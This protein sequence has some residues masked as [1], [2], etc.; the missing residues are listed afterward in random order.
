MLDMNRDTYKI[1]EGQSIKITAH[2][3]NPKEV[4]VFVLREASPG[5]GPKSRSENDVRRLTT[6]HYYYLFRATLLTSAVPFTKNRTSLKFL[7]EQ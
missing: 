4:G 5:S 7:I 3:L 2:F 6:E 1:S